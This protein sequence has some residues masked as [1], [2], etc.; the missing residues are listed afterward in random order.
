MANTKR[1]YRWFLFLA[2]VLSFFYVVFFD[3][4]PTAVA[5]FFVSGGVWYFL[6]QRKTR[7]LDAPKPK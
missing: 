3:R 1:A 7:E 4:S 6:E 2:A 5:A